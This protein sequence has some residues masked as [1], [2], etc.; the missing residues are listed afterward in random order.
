MGHR[1]PTQV[2]NRNGAPKQGLPHLRPIPASSIS[3]LTARL[4]AQSSLQQRAAAAPAGSAQQRLDSVRVQATEARP[5]PVTYAPPAAQS[6]VLKVAD[7][8]VS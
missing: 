3:F 6:V 8:E 2:V 1:R 7:K 5:A 4:A